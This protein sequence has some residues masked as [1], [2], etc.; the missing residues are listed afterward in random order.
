VASSFNRLV[1]AVIVACALA[2]CSGSKGDAGSTGLAG[3]PGPTGTTGGSGGVPNVTTAK[4][5]KA[6]ITSVTV[7]A[8]TKA[9]VKFRLSSEIDLPLRGLP[10]ANV[11]F[12]I[13]QLRGGVGGAGS[14]WRSYAT[15]LDGS[16]V[17]ATAEAANA[18]G[19][20]FRDNGDGTYE[21]T[22]SKPL[23]GYGPAGASYDGT[24]T[25][26]V[27]MELRSTATALL[28]A[29][30]NAPYTFV[31]ATGST[32]VFPVRREI[33][34]NDTCFACHDRLEFHG[35]PRTDVQY[36]VTCHNTGTA[37]G[38][39][40]NN[41]LAMVTMVHKIHM[42]VKLTNGYRITGNGNVV[43]E[44]GGPT[45]VV[46][47]QDQRNCQTCH[48]ESDAD[49]PDASN[50]RTTPYSRACGA[51]HDNVN[52]ATGL[53]HGP[54]TNPGGPATDDQ[55]VT[56][57]GPNSTV[58]NG[59]L[60]VDYVHRIP[61]LEASKKYKYNI[62]SVTN[63]AVGQQPV[64]RFSVTDPTNNNAPYNILTDP[65]FRVAAGGAS[66]LALSIGWNTANYTN[67]DSG[68]ATALTGTPAQ[69]ISIN[70]LTISGGT[71]AAGP[72]ANGAFTS[73][74]PIPIPAGV[75]GT[76]GVAIDGHP[77]LDADGDGVV[78]RIAVTNVI[79]YTAL[80]GSTRTPRRDIVNTKKCDDCHKQLS[81][82]GNNRTDEAQVCA[83]C[84]NPNATDIS[85]RAAASGSCATGTND[86]PIDLKYMIHAIHNGEESGY[87][88]CGFGNN[89]VSF[90][91]VRYPGK[92]NNCEGCHLTPAANATA[93]YYPV[94]SAKV[95]ATTVDVGALRNST[96]DDVA[97]SPNVAVC[98]GCH[99]TAAAEAH[100]LQN[101]GSKT[102]S[103][104]ADGTTAGGPLETCVLCHGPDRVADV[105]EVHKIGSFEFQ[106]PANP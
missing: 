105:K 104:N 8:D 98:S 102:L 11:R 46:F 63:A 83:M 62:L 35:G 90:A 69:P 21:Y 5:I 43:Y 45:G 33:V 29:S 18:T 93:S 19:A 64:I 28:A 44:F 37:D 81:L 96:T 7:A 48:Q 68:S 67:K 57:H 79:N 34:D 20:V 71:P 94:D 23:N 22:F 41:S 103:K 85:R 91:E 82:H 95:L 76:L 30:N 50:W 51:C 17:Q 54:A 53:N 40:P 31:P 14:E 56:C 78:D 106:A 100:M 80:T 75:T 72:D 39:A 58:Q 36:C 25:H 13:A 27:G 49:T 70:P 55:C 1:F 97:W 52:F 15:R 89:F 9:T 6:L 66:R 74:S 26:R 12:T 24:L 38:Q 73:T 86:Q 77:A 88:A 4:S 32:T 101:G 61:T 16:T 2:A 3:P 84:H 65:T 99:L 60:K 92:L 10:A 59:L 87:G 42:G 47:P